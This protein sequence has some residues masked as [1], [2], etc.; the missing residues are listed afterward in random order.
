MLALHPTDARLAK[1]V[2]GSW[3]LVDQNTGATTTQDELYHVRAVCDGSS[4]KVY[5]WQDG[6]LETEI[7][8]GTV[9]DVATTTT[10]NFA[11]QPNSVHAVDNIRI[12]SDDLENSYTF[13][14]NTANELT[15]MTGPNGT[16]TFTYD[17]WGRQTAKTLNSVTDTYA[18]RYGGMLYSVDLV[19]D[20]TF[21]IEYAYDASG[22]RRSRTAN[23]STA[24]YRVDAA[25][26]HINENDSLGNLVATQI[27]P[28]NE[29]HRLISVI[30]G[31]NPTTGNWLYVHQDHLGSTRSVTDNTKS[32]WS[33]YDYSPFGGI[34]GASGDGV[35]TRYTAQ[36]FEGLLSLHLFH[37]RVYDPMIGRWYARDR[38]GMVDGPNLYTYVQNSPVSH[39]DID[40]DLVWFIGAALYMAC[41]LFVA[42]GNR[43]YYDGIGGWGGFRPNTNDDY[44][45]CVTSCRASRYCVNPIGSGLVGILGEWLDLTI[46]E[47][48]G[49]PDRAESLRD[50][51]SNADGIVASFKFWRSC[52]SNCTARGYNS[53]APHSAPHPN[54]KCK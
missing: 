36:D 2:G 24:S 40:G 3:S 15:S 29:D 8:S 42:G 30:Q 53:T 17:A 48:A 33:I 39:I 47:M 37:N 21:D 14:Y 19:S 5:R 1:Y 32:P 22:H 20:S 7:L 6:E 10:L 28:D 46:G 49:V 12:L 38:L 13:S 43:I 11:A 9:T 52:S 54:I 35:D 4:I 18:Y 51:C 27:H 23:G 26:A 31:D 44:K 50:M 25:G 34:L 45:H 16:T 41:P